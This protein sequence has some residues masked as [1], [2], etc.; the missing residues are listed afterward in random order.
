MTVFIPLSGH[1]TPYPIKNMFCAKAKECLESRLKM[2]A[3][4]YQ[5]YQPSFTPLQGE[6]EGVGGWKLPGS[7]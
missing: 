2:K 4:G 1:M 7:I 3:A 6:G 5:A